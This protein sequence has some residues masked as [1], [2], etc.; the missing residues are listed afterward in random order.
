MAKKTFLIIILQLFYFVLIH[1]QDSIASKI[2]IF[3]EANYIMAALSYR[4]YVN[5]N[6]VVK[7]RNNTYYEYYCTPG[8]YN[9]YL[10][11]NPNN[12]VKL[13]VEEGQTYYIKMGIVS[14]F[15]RV[16]P[17]LVPV[18]N[19]WAETAISRMGIH[20]IDENNIQ[21]IRPKNRVG[22]NCNF[23]GGFQQIP[24]ITTTNGDDSKISFGGGFSF[25]LQYGYEMS[26]Y[27]D[28][29]ADLNYQLSSLTPELENA[30]VMFGRGHIAITPSLIVP[31]DG[32][33]SMR[34]KLGAGLNYNFSP[35]LEIECD[36]LTGGFNDTWKYKDAPGFHIS[37]VYEMNYT[38]RFTAMVGLKYTNVKYEFGSSKYQ[39]TPSIEFVR[40]DGQGLDLLCGIYY[41]F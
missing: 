6:M 34:L 36:Q 23:G 18:E 29:S 21:T 5:N 41:H 39:H 40:P 3:R 28:I 35:E 7:I 26:K 4:V 11:E 17:E 14:N 27:F 38:E 24:M 30:L 25:G 15:W 1:G 22:V 33:Y 31:I 19:Q 12:I 10:R 8:E 13:D 20:K 2:V 9:I 37:F 16:I 32:G